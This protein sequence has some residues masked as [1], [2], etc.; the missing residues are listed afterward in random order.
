MQPTFPAPAGRTVLSF[1]LIV[2]DSLGLPNA[3]DTA[4]VTVTSAPILLAELT[5]V[6]NN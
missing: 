3:P 6:W 4:V 5:A 1:S 2:T